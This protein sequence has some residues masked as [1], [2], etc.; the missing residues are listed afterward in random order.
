MQDVKV[1]YCVHAFMCMIAE[2][3]YGMHAIA[4]LL[5][6][7]L[8]LQVTTVYTIK[9][10]G[11]KTT[12]RYKTDA[13]HIMISYIASYIISYCSYSLKLL[14]TKLFLNFVIFEAPTKILSLKIS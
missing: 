11:I 13:L 5:L 9:T 12:V 4:H 6:L 2:F 8:Y 14:R 1:V 10:D 3:M 7:Y